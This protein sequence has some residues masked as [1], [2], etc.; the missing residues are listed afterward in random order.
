MQNVLAVISLKKIISNAEQ[1]LARTQKPLIAVVKDDAYG[2]GAE[3]VAR[4]LEE[5][6]YTFAVATVD[7]G[8]AL[9]AAGITKEILVLTPPLGE[10]EALRAAEYGLVVTASS[11]ASLNL[12]RRTAKKYGATV[13]AHLAVNTGMNRY[14]FRP[15]RVKT[16]CRIAKAYGIAIEGVYSHLYAPENKGARMTQTNIFAQACKTAREFFPDAIRHL[17]ATGGALAGGELFDAVRVGI[18]LYGYL[19]Q[20]FE[21]AAELKP[22]MKLYA[23][24]AQSGTFLG[25]GVGYAPAQKKYGRLYTLRLGYGDGFFRAGGLGIGKLCMDACIRE[26]RGD[27]GRRKL[28]LKDVSAYARAL[29]TTEYEILVAATRKAVKIYV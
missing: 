26:G 13:R 12:L 16:A 27:F 29:G 22:A 25:G 17:S 18:G 24:V 11:I 9:K 8:A 1:F 4:A 6:V 21:G 7:E 28:V 15:D 19:P 5:K 2:H 20:G 23:T 10:E 14:G 3:E